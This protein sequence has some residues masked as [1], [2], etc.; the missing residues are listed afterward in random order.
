MAQLLLQAL[1]VSDVGGDLDGDRGGVDDC[2]QRLQLPV[3]LALSGDLTGQAGQP[4]QGAF[5]EF[6]P[7]RNGAFLP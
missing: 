7:E 1:A 5:V 2:P 6:G 3:P 4:G